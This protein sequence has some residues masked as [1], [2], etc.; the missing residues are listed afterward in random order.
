MNANDPRLRFRVFIDSQ[1]VDETWVNTRDPE[2]LRT[3]K[4][5]WAHHQDLIWQ[6]QTDH[7]PWLIEI[8]DPATPE[9]QALRFGTDETGIQQPAVDLG[10]LLQQITTRSRGGGPHLAEH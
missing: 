4:H 3:V 1:L 7:K 9:D 5:V 10:A 2:P 6:A 8:Y